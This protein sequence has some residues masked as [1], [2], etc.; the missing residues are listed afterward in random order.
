M[1]TRA[2]A[3]THKRSLKS[4]LWYVLG[5]KEAG[6]CCN[7]KCIRSGIC[8]GRLSWRRTWQPIKAIS[9]ANQPP[10]L[11]QLALK[12]YTKNTH[13]GLYNIQKLQSLQLVKS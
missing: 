9:E 6:M 4:L 13:K 12:D 8:Q 7:Y 10:V 3:Y 2:N 1:R 5:F 11:Y